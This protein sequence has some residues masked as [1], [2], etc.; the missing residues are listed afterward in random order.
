MENEKYFYKNLSLKKFQ[1]IKPKWCGTKVFKYIM[2]IKFERKA[3]LLRY[4]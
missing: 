4:L 2:E 1:K 3:I